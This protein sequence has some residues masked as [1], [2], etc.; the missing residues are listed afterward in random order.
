MLTMFNG[1]ACI[2]VRDWQ[3][4]GLSLDQFKYDSKNGLLR[5]A[6]RSTDGNTLIILDSIVKKERREMIEKI[7]NTALQKESKETVEPVRNEDI[8][9]FRKQNLSESQVQ[10][11]ALQSAM[12][13]TIIKMYGESSAI[14]A[15]LGKKIVA[16]EFWQ[17]AQEFQL[18]ETANTDGRFFGVTP[19]TCA[20]S[21]QRA[22]EKYQQEGLSAL[23]P[24]NLGNSNA[25]KVSRPIENL[26]LSIWRQHDKPF[27]TRVTELYRE[28]V[29]G[30]VTLFDKETGE[31]FN[32]S[33]FKAV[34]IS[35]TTVWRILKANPNYTACYPSRNG[36]FDYQNALRPKH[37]RKHGEFSLSKISMDDVALSR[38]SAKGWAYKYIAVDV[39]SGYY[40]RPAYIIGKPT[41]DT[42]V[43]SFRNMFI[44]LMQLGLG[45]PR[46]LEVEHHLMENLDFLN[47]LFEFTR[48]CNSPTEKRAEHNIKSLK[49]GTAKQNGHTRGRW[50]AK[51]EAY[52]A[53][54][55]KVDGDYTEPE[56]DLRTV[57]ADDLSDIE[58]HNN[59][60]HPDQKTFPGMTRRDVLIQRAN[61]NCPKIEWSR[62]IRYLGNETSTSIRNND[63]VRCCNGEYQLTDFAS[64][65]RLKSNNNKVTAYWLP[66]D[67]G[68]TQTVYLYQ[69]DTYIGTAD[70][71]QRYSYNE[72]Q[73]ERTD[74]DTANML[75]QNK[76]V[77]KFDKAVKDRQNELF[78][79]GIE[80][81]LQESSNTVTDKEDPP[82]IIP[83]EIPENE[84]PKNYEQDEFNS[85]DLISWA[86]EMM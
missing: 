83:E 20:R 25:Q 32:P 43:E 42:V 4:A 37:H 78:D 27:C 11:L 13:R 6:R 45:M 28:W 65:S 23:L 39:V 77:A 62:I 47:D 52:R 82:L 74:E 34:P 71:R 30:G 7:V 55:N 86:M 58:K 18:R 31:V 21:L 66:E 22:I 70:N 19:Y 9:F 3:D 10:K 49:W 36:H 76:R 12:F 38:K 63:Y 57:I 85:D 41:A 69:G 81:A 8:E 67:D 26:L 73:A 44:E 48:F 15:R 46:E 16:K 35:D 60:L 61:P 53:I 75:Y 72:C 54:R 64:L 68:S 14:R 40:F 2:S 1:N 17:S 80:T 5:I 59:E 29:K 24:K 33:D 56:Y 79:L 51:H 84:Q 50:Y